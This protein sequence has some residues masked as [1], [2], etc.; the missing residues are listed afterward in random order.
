[1]ESSI[2]EF[3]ASCRI[4]SR[5]SWT[6]GGDLHQHGVNHN[7]LARMDQNPSVMTVRGG[8]SSARR[9]RGATDPRSVQRRESWL[10]RHDTTLA[11]RERFARKIMRL[12]IHTKFTP[13]ISDRRGGRD[14]PKS[15]EPL[16]SVGGASRRRGGHFEGGPRGFARCRGRDHERS[17]AASELGEEPSVIPAAESKVRLESRS[18]GGDAGHQQLRRSRRDETLTLSPAR[19]MAYTSLS[20]SFRLAETPR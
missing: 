18:R 13:E 3:T 4:T 7:E 19:A 17:S 10:F 2:F 5:N 9:T 14:R 16:V 20:D 15:D 8:E 11:E 12:I 6:P 1:M